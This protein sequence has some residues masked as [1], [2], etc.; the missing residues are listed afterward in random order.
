[1]DIVKGYIPV[2]KMVHQAIKHRKYKDTSSGTIIPQ[3][4][5]RWR[6]KGMRLK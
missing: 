5:S 2:Y 4:M 6:R 3:D 1:M